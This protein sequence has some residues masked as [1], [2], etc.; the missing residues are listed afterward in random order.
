[1]FTI[2]LLEKILDLFPA[3]IPFAFADLED[4]GFEEGVGL[5]RPASAF[6]GRRIPTNKLLD[7]IELNPLEPSVDCGTMNTNLIRDLFWRNSLFHQT[8]ANTYLRDTLIYM[9]HMT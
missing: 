6:L 9:R 7:S 2:I 4:M 5:V 3:T 1:V 8:M